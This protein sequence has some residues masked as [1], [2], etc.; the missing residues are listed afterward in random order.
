M[1]TRGCAAVCSWTLQPR[2]FSA[3]P[4]AW[5]PPWRGLR[6]IAGSWHLS[7]S[8]HPDHQGEAGHRQDM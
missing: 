5:S 8:A 2:R 3:P 7:C 4:W 1:R 6:V